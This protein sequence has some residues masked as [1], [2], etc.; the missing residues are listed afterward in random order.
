MPRGKKSSFSFAGQLEKMVATLKEQR[1]KHSDALRSIDDIF[2]K[3]GITTHLAEEGQE[4]PARRGRPP[5]KKRGRKPGRPAKNAGAGAVV[6]D[7]SVTMRKSGKKAKGGKRG[8]FST[9]GPDSILA[10]VK[11]AGAKGA[12][13]AEITKNW[14]GEGRGTGIYVVIGKLVREKKLKKQKIVGGQGSRYTVGG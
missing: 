14:T 7:D 2:A 3:I 6:L 9:T 10:F 12:T 13:G 5:G 11:K 1:T 4:A 8:S